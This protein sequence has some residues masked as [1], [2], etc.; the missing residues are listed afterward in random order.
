[1]I[2]WFSEKAHW[3][4][5]GRS[6]PN[7]TLLLYKPAKSLHIQDEGI[8]GGAS[9]VAD[10]SAGRFGDIG[11]FLPWGKRDT[12]Y[13]TDRRIRFLLFK[14]QFGHVFFPDGFY[15]E[16]SWRAI[17]P[18]VRNSRSALRFRCGW[19]MPTLDSGVLFIHA[20]NPPEG[21]AG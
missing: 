13:A 9:K 12:V 20:L 5:R 19:Q 10:K 21:L 8:A 15:R 7:C 18:S 14:A 6:C 3:C 1:M 4:W 2:S 17:N 16:L 11:Q